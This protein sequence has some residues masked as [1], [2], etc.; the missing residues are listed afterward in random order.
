MAS[1]LG[2]LLQ[3]VY[4]GDLT[5]RA[6]DEVRAMRAECQEVETGL[7]L[8]RRVVQGR[9]DIVGLERQRRADG[10]DPEVLGGPTA[11]ARSTAPR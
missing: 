3:P 8:L 4:L 6:M 1:D 9:L 2:E 7:S 11:P 10:G 5:T